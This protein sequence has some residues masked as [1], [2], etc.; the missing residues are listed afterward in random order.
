MVYSIRVSPDSNMRPDVDIVKVELID[1]PAGT[2]YIEAFIFYGAQIWSLKSYMDENYYTRDAS[3]YVT[4]G[5]FLLKIPQHL[6]WKD[7]PIPWGNIDFRV[8]CSAGGKDYWASATLEAPPPIVTLVDF[9]C[10]KQEGG[11]SYHRLGG[12]CMQA[13]RP[14]PTSQH[15]RKVTL[16]VSTEQ[17][18]F[19][20]LG[21]T[22][23]AED[24]R[25]F[26]DNIAFQTG[27]TQTFLAAMTPTYADGSCIPNQPCVKSDFLKITFGQTPTPAAKITALTVTYFEGGAQ[28]TETI[29]TPQSTIKADPDKPISISVTYRNTGTTLLHSLPWI[30]ALKD[31]TVFHDKPYVGGG[32]PP[33]LPVT[34][35]PNAEATKTLPQFTVPNT[36]TQV[37]VK[38]LDWLSKIST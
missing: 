23:V 9:G 32:E 20:S 35:E 18:T 37:A 27:S 7:Y 6:F 17:G 12:T 31:T 34:L 14:Y 33:H 29:T 5:Y 21:S 28:K 13:G 11:L 2:E 8:K 38:I 4:G 25:F 19:V 24:G 10:T 26:F 16:L 3:G 22:D 1:P 36:A 15:A 30:T